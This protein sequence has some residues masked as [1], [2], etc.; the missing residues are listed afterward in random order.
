[1]GLGIKFRRQAVLAVVAFALAAGTG[2]VMA[3]S[4]GAAI[5][6]QWG[7]AFV[8]KPS[9]AGI[10]DVNHQAG[11]WPAAF[12]VHVSPGVV[13]EVVVSF[14]QIAG[15]GGVVHAT[16]VSPNPAW[17]QAEEW[18][19]SGANEDV[20]IR[21]FQ[22]GGTPVFVPFS[23]TYSRSSSGPIPPGR[24]YG[25][26]RFHPSTGMATGFNSAGGA[27][28][29]TASGTGVW[30]VRLP[31][32][33]SSTEAG[34]VQVT[35]VNVNKPAKCEVGAWSA[36]AAAQT[37]VVRCYN[38]GVTPLETGW[39][40]TYD[41]GRTVLGTQP[42]NFAYTFDNQPTLAGPYAPT[43][44]G[45]NFNSAGGTN[46][47][48]TAGAGLRL[49]TF[50][51]VGVLPDNVLVTPF[52]G[53]GGFCNL[54]ALWATSAAAPQ[55]LVRDVACYTAAGKLVNRASFVTYASRS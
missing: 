54:L 29:V 25:Y 4:A 45:V 40:L 10:P 2:A 13:G 22:P 33:G 38:A 47:V 49:V 42:K 12:K 6:D 55:V 48:R 41:R 53:V 21:C 43:P 52:K 23:V 27:S 34:N 36:T 31:G 18:R 32:L 11:S 44:A 19:P 9:V 20:V 39:N 3:E 24:A 5:P 8:N 17:C 7:F 46:S 50:P 14:P 28:A 51:M 16:A 37:F 15:Q 26:V 30:K 1:M 35:A